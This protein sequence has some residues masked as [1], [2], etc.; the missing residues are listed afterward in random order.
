MKYFL[1][2][3]FFLIGCA[4]PHFISD[5]D[6][7]VSMGPFFNQSLYYCERVSSKNDFIPVCTEAFIIGDWY[8]RQKF[9]QK[10]E[11]FLKN[12]PAPPV[13]NEYK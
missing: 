3:S 13:H 2:I 5:K 1:L 8:S 10:N 12:S 4:S 9:I 7:W 11:S 6:A